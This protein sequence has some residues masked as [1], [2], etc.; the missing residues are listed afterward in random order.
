MTKTNGEI[1]QAKINRTYEEAEIA[2][3]CSC[4]EARTIGCGAISAD[5]KRSC[6]STV[7][8]LADMSQEDLNTLFDAVWEEV[9]RRYV[10]AIKANRENRSGKES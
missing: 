1:L 3:D 5:P 10:E 9:D 6:D 2:S 8:A 4:A 7:S